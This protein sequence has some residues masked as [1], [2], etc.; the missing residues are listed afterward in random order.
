MERHRELITNPSDMSVLFG[1]A[2]IVAML[3]WLYLGFAVA[4]R[5]H[6]SVDVAWFVLLMVA[7]DV[8]AA[9]AL[10]HYVGIKVNM[11]G[12]Q[13]G[14][15]DFPAAGWPCLVQP[16]SP[17]EVYTYPDFHAEHVLD[18]REAI[19]FNSIEGSTSRLRRCQLHLNAEQGSASVH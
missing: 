7:P 15:E 9:R 6:E 17:E 16:V 11:Y 3:C 10:S 8:L 1:F 2:G 14:V 5:V 13:K 18:E 4:R 12:T 19:T